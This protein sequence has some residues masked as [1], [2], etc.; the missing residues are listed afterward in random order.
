MDWAKTDYGFRLVYLLFPFIPTWLIL[1]KAA[2]TLWEILLT[3]DDDDPLHVYTE[4][5]SNRIAFLVM[6]LFIAGCMAFILC[7]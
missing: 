5:R 1:K 4:D 6:L 7:T 3:Q 2:T